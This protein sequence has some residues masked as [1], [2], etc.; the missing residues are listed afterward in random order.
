MG[1][2]LRLFPSSSFFKALICLSMTAAKVP[3]SVPVASDTRAETL[4]KGDE[5]KIGS[6]NQWQILTRLPS[7]TQ[8]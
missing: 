4:Q 5:L 7:Y 1:V 8:N 2:R 3:V 6:Q